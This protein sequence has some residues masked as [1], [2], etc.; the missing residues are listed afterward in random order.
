[1]A[2]KT[3]YVDTGALMDAAIHSQVGADEGFFWLLINTGPNTFTV[4]QAASGHTLV[5]TMTVPTLTSARFFTRR[6]APD[7]FITYRS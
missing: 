4:T 7:T 6:T 3:E 1:M 5:G 2:R